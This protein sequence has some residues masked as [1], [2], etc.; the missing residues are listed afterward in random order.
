MTR[1]SNKERITGGDLVSAES[2]IGNCVEMKVLDSRLG[3]LWPLPD[4]AT[5][6]S[7][8]IDLR[9]CIDGPIRLEPGETQLLSS[10]F[11]MH[12]ADPRLAAV[13]LPRSGQGHKRGLV[14]GNLVGLIDSDYQG[15]LMMSCWNRSTT[16]LTIEP[17]ERIAQLVMLPVVRAQLRKVEEFAP[18]QRAA[19]G[20]GHTGNA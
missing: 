15:P 2:S 13:I 5:E 19:G 1:A 7:A 10:G 12:I 18:S 6:G 20:F 16:A 3:S 9:A 17:G 14:L 4:Y 8:G 11:A